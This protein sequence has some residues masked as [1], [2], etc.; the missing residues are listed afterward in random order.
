MTVQLK[1]D[2]ARWIQW[3]SQTW[4]CGQRNQPGWR[5]CVLALCGSAVGRGS[6]CHSAPV[7]E[8]WRCWHHGFVNKSVGA[9][10]MAGMGRWWRRATSSKLLS[11]HGRARAVVS[12]PGR[13]PIAVGEGTWVSRLR[14]DRLPWKDKSVACPWWLVRDAS[15]M[16]AGCD[17]ARVTRCSNETPRP[18]QVLLLAHQLSFASK[19][20]VI[21]ESQPRSREEDSTWTVMELGLQSSNPRSTQF[22]CV[23]VQLG[24]VFCCRLA[25]RGTKDGRTAGQRCRCR[26]AAPAAPESKKC[27]A[28]TETAPVPCWKRGR[29]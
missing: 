29:A 9:S 11:R 13:E 5:I 1:G 26:R 28:P 22:M 8:R 25:N 7:L 12:P 17:E 6:N 10:R 3:G 18:G 20:R 16:N 23:S 24:I 15:L 4:R 14:K 19:W 27:P 21:D 2:R